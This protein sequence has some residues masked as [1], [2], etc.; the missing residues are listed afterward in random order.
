MRKFYILMILVFAA[1]FSVQA[2]NDEK[3]DDNKEYVV[4]SK[5]DVLSDET[6]ATDPT[7][8]RRYLNG[9]SDLCNMV[10]NASSQNSVYYKVYPFYSSSDENLD[11]STTT[12]GGNGDMFMALYCDPF[13]PTNP[14]LNILGIDD[15]GGPGSM[16]AFDPADNYTIT[17]NTQYYM[18]ISTWS[19]GNVGSYDI[20]L[21]GDF[22]FG[23]LAPPPPPPSVPLSNW[24]FALIGLFAVT[25]VFFK[26]RR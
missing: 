1:S 4:Q 10:S 8:G 14:D 17:A 12:T 2:I 20:A 7:Y 18:V 9:F 16:P 25:L 24:A 22:V 11:I 21:G 13:D 19:N 6:L 5:A 15:D 23:T 26:F 3:T